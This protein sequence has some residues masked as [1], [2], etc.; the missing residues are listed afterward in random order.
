MKMEIRLHSQEIIREIDTVQPKTALK[1][2]D[3]KML[4]YNK[5]HKESDIL[6][7]RNISV[8]GVD[9]TIHYNSVM[10]YFGNQ[11]VY[12]GRWSIPYNY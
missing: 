10:T 6:V 4:G 8:E 9:G 5:P 3:A 7:T 1:I 12:L 2:Y 11:L